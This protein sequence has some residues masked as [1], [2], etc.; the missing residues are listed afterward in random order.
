VTKEGKVIET[1]VVHEPPKASD[2]PI[3]EPPE[4]ELEAGK[5]DTVQIDRLKKLCGDDYYNK[6]ALCPVDGHAVVIHADSVHL[7]FK[8]GQ[9]IFF[10]SETCAQRFRENMSKYESSAGDPRFLPMPA[11]DELHV[12]CIDC[13]SEI[14]VH[15]DTPRVLFKH[16][17]ALFFKSYACVA[18]WTKNPQSYLAGS[19]LSGLFVK[20]GLGKVD[21]VCPVTGKKININPKSPSVE[22]TNGQRIY[23]CCSGCPPP[24]VRDLVTYMRK[25]GETFVHPPTPELAGFL[26]VCPSCPGKISPNDETPRVQ[27]RGGQNLYFHSNDCLDDFNTTPALYLSTATMPV[28]EE[29]WYKQKFAGERQ[30]LE[31]ERHKKE[32][33]LKAL[34]DRKE[35]ELRALQDKEVEVSKREKF[36]H[37]IKESAQQQPIEVTKHGGAKERGGAK[38]G[39]KE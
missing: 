28:K 35:A 30:K 39:W 24:L 13:K 27:F 25:P 32:V 9:N 19:V 34:R 31:E 6:G 7:P 14:C 3:R 20:E 4:V 23:T 29:E 18:N 36:T 33:E 10:D 5:V 22:F 16:G 37:I 11:W 12:H 38:E 15:D 1:K 26:L 17:Q 21:A 2:L 8:H